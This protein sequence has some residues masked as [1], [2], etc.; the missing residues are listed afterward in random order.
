M[1][2]NDKETGAFDPPR[3]TRGRPVH[4][5][6]HDGVALYQGGG[7]TAQK[8]QC[9]ASTDGILFLLGGTHKFNESL[10]AS[11][12]GN[13]LNGGTDFPFFKSMWHTTLALWTV[14]RIMSGPG[15]S[16]PSCMFPTLFTSERISCGVLLSSIKSSTMLSWK[17]SGVVCTARR[18]LWGIGVRA[19]GQACRQTPSVRGYWYPW[20]FIFTFKLSSP[21]SEPDR[22]N[23]FFPKT[24]E[25]AKP[26]HHPGTN[27]T[28]AINAF[29]IRCTAEQHG[30]SE[31]LLAADVRAMS[32]C[33]SFALA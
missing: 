2:P 22:S 17:T 4:Q 9:F 10:D 7:F 3:C 23:D 12:E 15:A 31:S 14:V 33:T 1:V 30:S 28:D 29:V 13:L 5:P 21:A 20:R 32:A 6:N 19:T 27:R 8:R 26:S 24:T 16:V 25:K 11:L 18:V